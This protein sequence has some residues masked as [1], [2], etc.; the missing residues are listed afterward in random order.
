M[1]LALATIPSP[2]ES[3]PQLDPVRAYLENARSRNTIRGYRSSFAQF[4]AWCDRTLVC[5]LPAAP[6]TIA[7]YLSDQ[8]GQLKASTLEHHLSA[9]AKAHKSAGLTSPI[10][11]NM[12]IAETLK[13][14]YESCVNRILSADT[15]NSVTDLLA[16]M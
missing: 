3:L 8:A 10:K 15:H 6:E 2:S 12:P 11:D 16:N 7:R 5:P 4:A 14:K 1:E 13:G 9:I